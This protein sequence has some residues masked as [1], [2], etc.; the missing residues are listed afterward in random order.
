[1]KKATHAASRIA[2]ENCQLRS[3]AQSLRAMVAQGCQQDLA[4]VQELDGM[5]SYPSIVGFLKYASDPL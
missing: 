1:M 3:E 4:R 5:C 2:E